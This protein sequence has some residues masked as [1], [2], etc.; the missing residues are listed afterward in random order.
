MKKSKTTS[1]LYIFFVIMIF[2]ALACMITA[3]CLCDY[4][5]DVPFADVW[6]SNMP[7]FILAGGFVAL[8]IALIIAAIVLRAKN[9]ELT[10]GEVAL[11]FQITVVLLLEVILCV[12][13]FIVWIIERIHDAISE[14]RCEKI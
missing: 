6:Q 11:A 2:A 5:F 10:R 9:N 13:I 12:P 7:S 3:L 8:N 1:K 14:A 4:R